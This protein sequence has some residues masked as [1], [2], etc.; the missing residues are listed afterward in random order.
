MTALRPHRSSPAKEWN[1]RQ[2]RYEWISKWLLGAGGI[3]LCAMILFV[4]A[5][6]SGY[7]ELPRK[8]QTLSAGGDRRVE[9]YHVPKLE[10]V[11][12]DLRVRAGDRVLYK[13][14]FDGTTQN[15][16]QMHYRAVVAPDTSIVALMRTQE[17]QVIRVLYDFDTGQCWI[18]RTCP[19]KEGASLLKR[20]QSKLPTEIFALEGTDRTALLRPPP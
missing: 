18:G 16:S 6:V 4:V 3:V 19:D 15:P 8:V 5:L 12:A 13:S 20:F 7:I 17:P 2:P 14:S 9:I 11:R 10:S 1:W